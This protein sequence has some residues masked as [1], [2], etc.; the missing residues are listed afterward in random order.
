VT[1]LAPEQ[2]GDLSDRPMPPIEV[3]EIDQP[4]RSHTVAQAAR[5]PSGTSQ[6]RPRSAYPRL[7]AIGHRRQP[8]GQPM[9]P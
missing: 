5:H 9:F 7:G 3:G 2:S 1:G 8:S 4:I 6:S